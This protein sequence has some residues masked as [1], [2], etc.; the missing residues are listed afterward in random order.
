MNL[1]IQW[2]KSG[3]STRSVGGRHMAMIGLCVWI[4]GGNWAVMV[5]RGF[6]T[7]E[8]GFWNLGI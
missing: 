5:I 6:H 1:R 4:G 7:S 3:S 2:M 8:P